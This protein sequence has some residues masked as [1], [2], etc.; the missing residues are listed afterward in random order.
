MWKVIAA[1]D[2]GYIQE[3]LQKLI[4]WEKMNCQLEA[5]LSNGQEVIERIETD[6]PDLIIT[7]IQMPV[8]NGLEVC[9]YVYETSPETPVILLTAY[10]DFAY[11]RT[12]IRYSVCDYVLKVSIMEELPAAVEK[13]TGRLERL[14]EETEKA[15][16]ENSGDLYLQIE[17][18]IEQ[19]YRFRLSLDEIAEALH[20]NRSY[21]S[22][23]YKNKTGVNLFD[24]ILSKR[25]EAAKEL[26]E[27]TDKKTYEISEAVGF[28]DAGYFS[29]MFK[30]KTGRS[31]KEYR[32]RVCDA[33]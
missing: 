13:A 5:V 31:P 33:E 2:E 9:R 23:L 7:D 28:E 16:K 11:A 8:M 4:D 10:S 21:L 3:A 17:H 24:A 15:E 29:R 30:R 12:A 19:N 22:R 14:K 18:Y 20:A 6:H 25:I 32:K 1:D 26:L 27:H